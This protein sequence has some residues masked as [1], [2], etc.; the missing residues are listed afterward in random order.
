MNDIFE[1]KKNRITLRYIILFQKISNLFYHGSESIPYLGPK[2]WNLVPENIK[3]PK[4]ISFKPRIKFW[5]LGSCP[6]QLCKLY[7]SQ[8]GFI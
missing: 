4:N 5:K 1:K 8:I 7:L 6:C 2:I 3:N